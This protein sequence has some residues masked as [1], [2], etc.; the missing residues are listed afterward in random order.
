MSHHPT[1]GGGGVEVGPEARRNAYPS[2]PET[3]LGPQARGRRTG[4]NKLA[5]S[6]PAG[7]ARAG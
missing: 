6:L 5:Q 1:I 2:E 4:D 7:R 3:N